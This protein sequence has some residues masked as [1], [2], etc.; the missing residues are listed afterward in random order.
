MPPAPVGDPGLEPLIAEVTESAD[1]RSRPKVT[2]R[3]E[4]TAAL[5]GSGFVAFA[6][7]CASRAVV[8]DLRT[9]V[10]AAALVVVYGLAHRTK[11]EATTG[12]TVPTEPVLVA[13]LF[14]SPIASVPA[15]VLAGLLLGSPW[16]DAPGGAVHEFFVRAATGWYCAGPVALVWAVELRSPA[17]ARWPVLLAA[18]ASQ[19]VC[20]AVAALLRCWALKIS[21][22]R[23]AEPLLFTFSVDSL[24]APLGVCAVLV[25]R[26]GP[27]V[28]F[29]SLVPVALVRVMATDRARRLRT[30]VRLGKELQRSRD[31]SR[32]DAMTGLAN[33]R[34]WEEAVTV[35]ERAALERDEGELMTVVLVADIDH[36]KLVND[37][38]GH[39]AG[40]D[41][42]RAFASTLREAAPQGALVARLGGD[43]FGVLFRT[44]DGDTRE[45][46]EFVSRLRSGM[47]A[48]RIACGARLFGLFG[49]RI[50]PDSTIDRGGHS[51]GRSQR[52][53]REGRSTRPA[54]IDGV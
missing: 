51:F 27:A 10:V 40:D 21:A 23:L 29:F 5:L 47:A 39:E 45:S 18:L 9:A 32:T 46:K 50:L 12:S 28:V 44:A 3:D 53:Q 19:F 11:F 2:R 38:F 4:A 17:L 52:R 8:H 42:L 31:E 14:V 37:S 26:G 41:L 7:I 1:L 43:E 22:R 6:A 48:C 25:S 13:L 54:R 16:R 36:L 20:D 49:R 30:A 34:A 15:L 33:W 35:T 24:L